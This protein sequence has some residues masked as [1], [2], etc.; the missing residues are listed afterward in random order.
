M[1]RSGPVRSCIELLSVQCVVCRENAFLL[2]DD[3]RSIFAYLH[4]AVSAQQL[5][6]LARSG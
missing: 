1:S 2:E 4:C 5:A 3:I 6:D